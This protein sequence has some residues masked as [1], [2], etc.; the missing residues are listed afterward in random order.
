[1]GR[2]ALLEYIVLPRNRAPSQHLDRES[3]ELNI[4]P[5]RH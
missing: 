2:E 3:N 1:M 5:P 4:G